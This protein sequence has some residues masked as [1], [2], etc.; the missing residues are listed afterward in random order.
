MVCPGAVSKTF[1][2]NSCFEILLGI[3][4]RSLWRVLTS[5]EG[6]DCKPPALPKW[7]PS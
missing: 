4:G 6:A 2:P 3:P 1:F 5:S 7:T